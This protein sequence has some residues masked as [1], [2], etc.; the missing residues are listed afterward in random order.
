[1]FRLLPAA[2]LQQ[3]LDFRNLY[4]SLAFR[5]K[6]TSAVQIGTDFEAKT[7]SGMILEALHDLVPTLM[8]GLQM[9]WSSLASRDGVI[10][11]DN[12]LIINMLDGIIRTF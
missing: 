7:N 1:M 2:S 12:P 8:E 9:P 11:S 10:A 5:V 4:L 3:N 6:L